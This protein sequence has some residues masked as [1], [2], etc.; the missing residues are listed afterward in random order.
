MYIKTEDY[1]ITYNK[2]CEYGGLISIWSISL[3][4]Y[5]EYWFI[6]Q[7]NEDGKEKGEVAFLYNTMYDEDKEYTYYIDKLEH[8]IKNAIVFLSNNLI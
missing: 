3:T 4:K 6:A 7:L 5:P 2:K 8:K 1:T